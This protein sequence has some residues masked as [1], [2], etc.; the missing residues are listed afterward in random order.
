MRL[1]ARIRALV[2][3]L[4]FASP[5]VG[6]EAEI[7]ALTERL[8]D[9]ESWLT[10]ADDELRIKRQALQELDDKIRQHG[11]QR[12]DLTRAFDTAASELDAISSSIVE[13]TAARDAA[14][15][16]LEAFLIAIH[17]G[18][19]AD[20]VQRLLGGPD[21]AAFDRQARYERAIID[22][23]EARLDAYRSTLERLA[24]TRLAEEAKRRQ[25]DE[26]EASLDRAIATLRQQRGER[27]GIIESLTRSIA[28]K[29]AEHD[30]L[31]ADRSRLRQLLDELPRLREFVVP[32]SRSAW[33]VDGELMRRFG[34]TRMG[35][36]RWRGVYFSA[37]VGAAVR[38]AA[39]GTV[40]F[41]DRLRG[42]GLL[43][44]LDHGNDELTLY[45]HTDTLFKR[46]GDPVQAGE[47]IA[48]AGQSGGQIDVGLYFEVRHEGSSIDPLDWLRQR[49]I[50]PGG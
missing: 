2:V 29:T 25:V 6:D 37:P 18:G 9:L 21:P 5:A 1:S 15:R 38:A 36:L 31:S 4:A 44:I 20:P 24:A 41:A 40:V 42:F 49:G 47:T 12:R 50:T 13:Q 17:R 27:R 35:Q 14:S 45:G 46:V 10:S 33:P 11:D 32:S 19:I 23:Q 48:T 30:R 22:A 16:D 26:H 28:D 7:D 34:E 3:L 8:N 39:G 43:T